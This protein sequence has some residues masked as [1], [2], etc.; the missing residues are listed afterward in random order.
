MISF[1]YACM[2]FFHQHFQRFCVF[3]FY[4]NKLI[5]F[6]TFTV[7]IL[8]YNYFILCVPQHSL[9][10]WKCFCTLDVTFEVIVTRPTL[11][12]IYLSKSHLCTHSHVLRLRYILQNC[13][14][15]HLIYNW[16]LCQTMMCLVL[17]LSSW[18][19]EEQHLCWRGFLSE[20]LSNARRRHCLVLMYTC[21][22]TMYYHP[23]VCFQKCIDK[24]W[25]TMKR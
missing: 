25:K 24:C 8:L 11:L 5:T 18:S 21:I 14:Q 10:S 12:M 3:V 15:K 19:C 17:L 6:Q 7:A 16:L 1:L 22:T 4:E 23:Y 20:S 9:H 2:E 13:I